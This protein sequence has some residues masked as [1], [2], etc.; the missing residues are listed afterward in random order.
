MSYRLTRLLF[1][2]I[3]VFLLV[4]VG[5][6][7]PGTAWAQSA[8]QLQKFGGED[9]L[10]ELVEKVHHEKPGDGPMQPAS[11]DPE[12]RSPQAR[13]QRGPYVS[14]Q[15]NVD[16]LGQNI[17]GDAA[18]EPSIAVNPNNSDKMAIGWR[19]F[20]TISSD[21]RQAGNAYTQDGGQ[22]W[23]FPGVLTPGTFRSDPVLD[24][25]GAGNF[26]YYS[27]QGNFTCDMFISSNGGMTWQGPI[28]AWGGDKNWLG[29]DRT[30]GM[31]N[32]H[33]YCTWTS[34]GSDNFTRS[35]DG[36][37]T[38]MNP[39]P[40][41]AYWGTIS[42]DPDARLFVC[43]WAGGS[44]FSV[45]RSSNAQNPGVTPTWD[46]TVY[47]DLGGSVSYFGGPNPGGL[48]GQTWIATNHS[49]GPHY[50][51][52][53]LLCSVD[54]PGTDPLDVHFVR[55]TD[56]G[57]TWSSPV[58]IND[59]PIGNKAWQWFGTMSVAPNGR[60]DVIWNDTRNTGQMNDC[61]LFYAYS[62]DGGATWSKNAQVTPTWNSVIGWPQQ[63]KIGDYY[64]MVSHDDGAHLAYAATFNGEQDVYYVK[65]FPDFSLEV[66]TDELPANTGGTVNFTLDAGS[67]NKDRNYLLLGGTRGS[68]PGFPLPGGLATLP[69]H[70]D[71]FTDYIL[72]N[73][74]TTLFTDF[75]GKLDDNG[76]AAAQLNAPPVPPELIGTVMTYAYCLNAPFDFVSKP[77]D[78]E[79]VP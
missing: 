73:L 38:Y 75:L 47:V 24:S 12:A 65:L 29:I 20:D 37:L 42:V 40:S 62:F 49:S 56:L 23:T 72:L 63:N 10:R 68:E 8:D 9:S 7:Q 18:N 19:Q 77:V 6:F 46:S 30:S 16:A 17:V 21:F 70:W 59:D 11:V 79:I 57:K 60:I 33:I 27:L 3:V 36:G 34:W 61:Q 76:Q 71:G 2:G 32:G 13:I 22:T 53:Y 58:R 54:P 67:D 15:V 1:F 26:F 55:S 45:E 50:G 44:D 4:S 31:A 5:A 69:I 43:G 14:V 64:D 28:P 66:D 52:I 35:I 51:E 25:D 78:V 74:N 48:L 41:E 39:I